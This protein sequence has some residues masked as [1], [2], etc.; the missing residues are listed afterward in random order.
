[1]TEKMQFADEVFSA[2]SAPAPDTLAALERR[3]R[4]ARISYRALSELIGIPKD[5][6]RRALQTGK[7]GAAFPRIPGAYGKD[8]SRLAAAVALLEQHAQERRTFAEAGKV[9]R[10][11]F[12]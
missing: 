7:A 1:M 11:C 6:I 5:S 10:L 3:R 4:A 12:D 2:L 8:T 9:R